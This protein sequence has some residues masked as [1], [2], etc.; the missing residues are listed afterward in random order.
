MIA[1]PAFGPGAQ[2]DEKA[3]PQGVNKLQSAGERLGAEQKQSFCRCHVAEET[4]WKWALEDFD[5]TRWLRAEKASG[6]WR[7]VMTLSCG[8]EQSLTP[9][10]M[11]GRWDDE[12]KA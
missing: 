6:F 3:V 5:G 12:E 8:P 10:E 2:G 1:V 11:D 9:P 4:A 7:D